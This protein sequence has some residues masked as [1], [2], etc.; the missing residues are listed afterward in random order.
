VRRKTF[1]LLV[2]TGGLVLA[3]VLL[4]AGGLL[5]WGYSF[6][7]SQVHDQLIAQKIVFPAKSNPEFKALPA[8][9]QAAMGGYAGQ[10]LTTGAQA[11]TYADHFI[12]VHLAE[13]GHG[14]TYAQLS[15]AALAQPRNTALAELVQTVF[16]GTTLRSMLLEAYG[17]WQFGQIA[18]YAAI[19]SFTGAALMLILS[20]AGLFHG[21]RVTAEAELLGPAVHHSPATV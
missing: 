11:K 15:A 17:F 21:R 9:D 6:A 14:K 7:S 18:L 19:A 3:A 4:V 2:S 10:T 20:I 1:D 8:A 13:M 16:R 5:M 12:A